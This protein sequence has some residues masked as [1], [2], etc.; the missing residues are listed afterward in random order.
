MRYCDDF[1]LLDSDRRR[2]KETILI[3]ANFL[4]ARRLMLHQERC[5]IR[6]SYAG[7]TF[8]GY[9]IWPTRRFLRKQSIRR[10]RRRLRWMKRAYARGEIHSRDIVPRLMSWQGHAKQADSKGLIRKLS[11]EWAFRRE[12]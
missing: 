9:R 2:L 7:V 11:R 4:T 8:V 1:V 10:F 5:S 3:T 12:G 6:P